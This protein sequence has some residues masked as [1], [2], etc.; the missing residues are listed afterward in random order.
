MA[1]RW[2]A[3]TSPSGSSMA[4]T[5]KEASIVIGMAL[6]GDPEQD[7]A[8]YFGVNQGRVAEIKG[9]SYGS[10][11]AAPPNELP[12]TGSPGPKGQKLRLYVRDALKI[13]QEKGSDGVADAIKELQDG[14][15]RFDKNGV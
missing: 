11:S 1:L 6:R 5:N 7:I 10:I 15:A 2:C 13:L 8:A 9:G 12:P 3:P 14:I 4:L